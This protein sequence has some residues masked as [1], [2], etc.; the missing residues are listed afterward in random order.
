MND[1]LANDRTFLAWLR[2]GIACFGLGFL[3]AKAALIIKAGGT[4]VS[5]KGLYGATG[6]L[7]G[8]SGAVLVMA[9]YLQHRQVRSVLKTTSRTPSIGGHARPLLLRSWPELFSRC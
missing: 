4:P 2:T 7:I 5:N 3:V 9:G 6:V 8:L 1:K